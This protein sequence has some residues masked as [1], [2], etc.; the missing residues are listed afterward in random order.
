MKTVTL[1]ALETEMLISFIR[2]GQSVTNAMTAGEME[3]DNMTWMNVNDL[4]EQLEWS[5][6][7][8]GGV[9]G[10]L[11]NKG[12]IENSGSSARGAKQPDFTVASAFIKM[13]FDLMEKANVDAAAD[14]M[15]IAA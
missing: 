6:Y 12:V 13:G 10:T 1:T 5:V 3:E 9:M 4:V 15:P 11:T 14:P 2:E 7:K 8:V